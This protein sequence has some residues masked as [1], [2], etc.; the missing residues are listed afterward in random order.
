[1]MTLVTRETMRGASLRTSFRL[2]CTCDD[3]KILPWSA[4]LTE[5]DVC[6]TAVMMMTAVLTM[7]TRA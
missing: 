5:E 1:M 3:V 7:M 4:C 6:M 2:S